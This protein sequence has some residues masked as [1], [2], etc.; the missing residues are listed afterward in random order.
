M[1][2][3]RMLQAPLRSQTALEGREQRQMR[4]E[5]L[6]LVW[7]TDEWIHRGSAADGLVGTV[8]YQGERAVEAEWLQ[9]GD[10]REVLARRHFCDDGEVLSIWQVE[11]ALQGRQVQVMVNRR[12]GTLTFLEGC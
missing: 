2:V 9:L 10:H 6:C 5:A 8:R 11:P 7:E 3:V 1:N 4:E 12:Q